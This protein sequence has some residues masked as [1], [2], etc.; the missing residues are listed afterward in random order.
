MEKDSYKEVWREQRLTVTER[1]ENLFGH[2]DPATP[3]GELLIERA[4]VRAGS[5]SFATAYC[6]SSPMKR[7]SGPG[8]DLTGISSIRFEPGSPSEQAWLEPFVE[9]SDL[10]VDQEWRFQEIFA[11]TPIQID[12]E[13]FRPPLWWTTSPTMHELPTHRRPHR[14]VLGLILYARGWS[15]RRRGNV[16]EILPWRVER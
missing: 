6:V 15:C 12:A 1:T 3:I 11:S 4:S 7:P 8:V 5:S 16:L 2:Y 14:D 10:H 13:E 9:P